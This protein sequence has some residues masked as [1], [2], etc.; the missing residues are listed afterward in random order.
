MR[1]IREL[2]E[3]EQQE[4]AHVHKTSTSYQARNRCQC[5]LLSQ[6]GYRVQALARLFKTIQLSIYNW[7]NR[8]EEGG[9]AGLENQK[10]KGRKPILKTTNATHVAAVEAS[11]D[12]ER[13][14]LKLAKADIEAQL[15]ATMSELT[16]KR[17]LKK[18]VTAGNASAS[19]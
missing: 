11:M 12:Q 16:W 5:V 4:L 18:L 17:F 6:Q 8:F 10:G 3:R 19:G 2:T 1:Y 13:Q 14:R 7:F 15:G 9:V